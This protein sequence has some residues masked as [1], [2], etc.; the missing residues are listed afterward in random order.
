MYYENVVFSIS[1]VGAL[2]W[3]HPS[4]ACPH[5][6]KR[7]EKYGDYCQERRAQC[8][9]GHKESR[10]HCGVHVY[11]VIDFRRLRLPQC[12]CR[13]R[14]ITVGRTKYDWTKHSFEHKLFETV[15]SGFAFSFSGDDRTTALGPY[16]N[17]AAGS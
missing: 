2:R 7:S 9:E 10:A 15:E 14:H 3:Q 13:R 11:A 8:S 17:F 6:E 5:R 4:W 1:R 12:F 16:N